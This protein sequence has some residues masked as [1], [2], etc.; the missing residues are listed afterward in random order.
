MADSGKK[1]EVTESLIRQMTRLALEHNAVNLSQGF[2][3][4]GPPIEPVLGIASALIGGE[5]DNLDIFDVNISDVAPDAGNLTIRE[6]LEKIYNPKKAMLNQYS[7]PFGI[8]PLRE[9]VGKYYKRFY[10]WDVDIQDNITIC[11]GATEAFAST[12]RTVCA[13]GDRVLI[14]EP[15]HEL[16][17]QQCALFY[18]QPEFTALVENNGAWDVDWED[19]ESQ[20]IKCKA[21]L[22]NTPHNPTGKVFTYQELER[23]VNFCVKHGIIIITDEIYEFMIFNNAKHYCLP[24]EFPQIKDLCVVINSVSKT[25][26]ATGWRIG[27]AIASKDITSKIRGVHDQMVLQAPTPIQSGVCAYLSMPTNYFLE[28]IP[29]K[30]LRRRE[31]LIPAL[32]KIGFEVAT[33]DSAYY[34]F[35]NYKKIEKLKKMTPTEASMFL[36]KI[37]GVATVPGDNFYSR[38]KHDQGQNYIR[39]CFVRT[40]DILLEAIARLEKWLL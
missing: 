15:F 16:Y 9:A 38:H 30:Y 29:R 26:S 17:P 37:C 25:C 21:V 39:F 4:E 19:F 22:L 23:M 40:D 5:M 7:I 3:N 1:P 20:A 27:W 24:H 2:P 36:V 11:L 31:I 32:R 6:L 10:E 13:E 18:V 33:P 34:A 14:F 28:E 12:L 35:C 8:L